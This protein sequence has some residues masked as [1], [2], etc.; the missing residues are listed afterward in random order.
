MLNIVLVEPLIPQN[1]GNIARTCA[2]TGARLHLIEPLGFS[3]SEKAL[4]RA[5]MDYWYQ[6]EVHRYTNFREF[7]ERHPGAKIW[8]ATTKAQHAYTEVTYGADDFIMFG[9]ESAGI[10]EEILVEHEY[11]APWFVIAEFTLLAIVVGFFR[12]DIQPLGRVEHPLR[13]GK[14]GKF[15]FQREL[16]IKLRSS[17]G[18]IQLEGSG[19]PLRGDSHH[20]IGERQRHCTFR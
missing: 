6:L 7:M 16:L 14:V 20:L 4:K 12:P 2:A 5:G 8:M 13:P 10:P 18:I 19:I 15:Q 1:T 3:L 9:K 11:I 17:S